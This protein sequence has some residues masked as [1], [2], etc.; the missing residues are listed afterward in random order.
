MKRTR[1]CMVALAAGGLLAASF[2]PASA[3]Q[4][5][6]EGIT[7]IKIGGGTSGITAATDT[8][9]RIGDQD[10]ESI[11]IA[12]WPIGGDPARTAQ[13]D[14]VQSAIAKT[15][16]MTTMTREQQTPFGIG[17]TDHR[18]RIDQG[19]LSPASIDVSSLG[20]IGRTATDRTQGAAHIIT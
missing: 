9:K 5:A 2:V 1:F 8:S 18:G 12:A 11:G 4:K 17:K 3:N 13:P 10:R 16:T 19:P 7:A 20:A 14:T 6:F 15:A